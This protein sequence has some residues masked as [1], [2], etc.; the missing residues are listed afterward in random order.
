MALNVG[1]KNG[2]CYISDG[3]QSGTHWSLLVADLKTMPY[4]GD[5]LGWLLP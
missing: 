4:C 2:G 5:P 1:C 3:K